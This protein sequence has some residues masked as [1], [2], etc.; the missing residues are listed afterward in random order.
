[1]SGRMFGGSTGRKSQGEAQRGEEVSG[2]REEE[3]GTDRLDTPPLLAEALSGTSCMYQPRVA[4]AASGGL[5]PAVSVGADGLASELEAPLHA[6]GLRET[7]VTTIA[8]TPP[9]PP[10]YL[11]KFLPKLWHAPQDMSFG[12]GGVLWHSSR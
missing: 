11:Q 9:P 4:E 2:K 12:G 10:T 7:C 1:M 6:S 5:P 3:G 8:N